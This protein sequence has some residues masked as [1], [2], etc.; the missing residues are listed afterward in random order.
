M[1]VDRHY[2]KKE[3]KVVNENLKKE[4]APWLRVLAIL[5]ANQNSS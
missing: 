1:E 2:S 4:M 3:V 5:V